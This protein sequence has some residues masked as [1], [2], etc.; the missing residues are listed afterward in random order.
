VVVL[1]TAGAVLAGSA[2]GAG[3]ALFGG[4][5]AVRTTA[6]TPSATR[7]AT[8]TPTSTLAPGA[9]DADPV[10]AAEAVGTA[11]L[12]AWETGDWATMQGQLD[13]SGGNLERALGGMNTRLGVTA[14]TT[15][16]GEPT[17]D[18]GTLPFSVTL[19]L[20][21][22]GDVTWSGELTIS[23]NEQAARSQVHFTAASVYPTLKTGQRLE[24]VASPDSRGDILDRKGRS[25]AK[26]PDLVANVLGRY[27]AGSGAAT[28]LQRVLADDLG[29]TE[30]RS[31]GVVDVQNQ[32][33]VKVVKTFPGGAQAPGVRTTLDVSY[34][35]AATTALAGTRS[36][37]AIVAIDVRTGEVRAVAN[38]PYTGVPPALSGRYAPGSTFKIV[39]ALAALRNGK[40]PSSTVS[41]PTT[42]NS[43]G[44]IFKNHEKA[45][46]RSMSLTEAFADSCNTAF[47]GLAR[48]LPAGALAS[49]AEDLGFNTDQPLPVASFGGSYPTPKDNA[50][51]AASAIGQGRVEASPL[52]MASVAAAVASGTYRQPR[53]LADCADCVTNPLPEAAKIRPMMRAVVT[54]G[55]GTAAAG[56]P[57][58]AVYA[59]TGTAEFGSGT[60][61][62][63]HAWFVGWQ[64]TTAFA[65]FVDVGA[66]GGETAAPI[67]A[68]FLRGLA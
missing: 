66:S 52:Q 63:N 64:G 37:A 4:G 15:T 14:V 25:L 56:V 34:Q 26:Q 42:I 67:A 49:A 41:C 38:R 45:P 19:T 33:V 61:L 65:V 11:Y 46:N 10:V 30:K 5:D 48:S 28:G 22:L 59:K 50:E 24:L 58:G 31:V 13:S 23:R 8:L 32:T 16:P 39:T 20:K 53:L 40:T 9:D 47:I 44:K 12:D 55:T 3:V 1:V 7:S 6:A 27:D 18:G 36:K 54:S 35:R 60:A 68:R 62:K 43:Y 21:D 51:L 57:G 2:V 29:G 17:P